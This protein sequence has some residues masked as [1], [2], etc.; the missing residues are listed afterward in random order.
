M[1]QGANKRVQRI[2][3][4]APQGDPTKLVV[5]SV[6]MGMSVWDRHYVIVSVVRVFLWDRH[7]EFVTMELSLW[8]RPFG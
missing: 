1:L 3:D 8:D 5:V 2:D 4:R 7:C 6:P